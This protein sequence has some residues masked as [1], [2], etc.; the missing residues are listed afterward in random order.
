MT[1]VSPPVSAT[2]STCSICETPL[3]REASR[4]RGVCAEC[5]NRARFPKQWA[6]FDRPEQCHCGV[7]WFSPAHYEECGRCLLPENAIATPE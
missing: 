3:V 6:G 5:D 7:G 2:S 1:V 4:Q